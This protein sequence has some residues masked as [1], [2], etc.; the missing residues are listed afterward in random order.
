MS[1]EEKEM[2]R[3]QFEAMCAAFEKLSE[4]LNKNRYGEF[5]KDLDKCKI[6]S[7][8]NGELVRTTTDREKFE[9]DLNKMLN[10]LNITN[11]G[12]TD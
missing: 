4:K 3:K 7:G 10:E 9:W 2:Y 8:D 12:K 1:E 5:D 6:F 11:N